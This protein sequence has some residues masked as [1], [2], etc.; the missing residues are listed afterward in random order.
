MTCRELAFPHHPP[1][2]PCR[3]GRR[4]D[5]AQRLLVERV[6]NRSHCRW[7][8]TTHVEHFHREPE[9]PGTRTHADSQ[10]FT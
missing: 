2:R 6:H 10:R 5:G 9:Q 1:D 4:R 3:A 7:P 8:G